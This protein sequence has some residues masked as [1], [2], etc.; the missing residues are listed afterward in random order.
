MILH[1]IE[2]WFVFLAVFAV[3][4]GLG[5]LLHTGISGG[6]MALAQDRIAGVIGNRIDYLKWQLGL[7]P[8]WR[9]DL[10]RNIG[11]SG[12]R[13]SVS[14][15]SRGDAAAANAGGGVKQLTFKRLGNVVEP[16]RQ[17]QVDKELAPDEI[18]DVEDQQ[19]ADDPLAADVHARSEMDHLDEAGTADEVSVAN[20]MMRPAGLS[21]PRGGLPDNL[22][23]IW[24]IGKR[25]EELLNSLG[26]Y[27]FSQ[28]ASWTPAE[29]HWVAARL[30]FPERL[31]RD[32][33][34]G[35]AIVLAAG[36]DPSTVSPS[37]RKTPPPTDD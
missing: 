19:L 17:D 29:A 23:R 37:N 15:E 26:I 6:P 25:N 11:W 12:R 14:A 33:W 28:I 27:H 30:T 31:E 9:P 4:C 24:G 1:F 10:Q 7:A 16:D 32:N 20:G 36:G 22:Q 13:T 5:A 35:Q 3:G 8:D 18:A 34:I 2:V 21:E